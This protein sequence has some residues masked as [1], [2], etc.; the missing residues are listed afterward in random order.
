MKRLTLIQN[1]LIHKSHS[2]TPH[3][4]SEFEYNNSVIND[5]INVDYFEIIIF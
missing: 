2:I 3:M 5:V 1:P 4:Y